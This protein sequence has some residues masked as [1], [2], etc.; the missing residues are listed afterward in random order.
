[1]NNDKR[2]EKVDNNIKKLNLSKR[3]DNES[4]LPTWT[5]VGAWNKSLDEMD[6]YGA[7]KRDYIW[8]SQLG[9]SQIDIWL[10]LNGTEP[11]NNFDIRAKRK[12]DAGV[13]WE[14][15]AEL[16]AKRAGIFL[17]KQD[18]V[19]Y[20]FEDTIKVV[21]KFDLMIG[22]KRNLKMIEDVKKALEIISLP[23]RF[24]KAMDSV[25]KNMNFETTLPARILEVKSSSAFM[26]EAQYKKGIPSENHALQCLHYL[27]ATEMNEGAI[28]YISKDDARM[29]EIP[30]WRDDKMLNDK[31]REILE[32]ATYY[33]RNKEKP[34]LEPTIIFDYNKGKF[35][36]NWNIKYSAYLTMLY[37]F[38]AE[39]N[40]QDAFKSKI[41]AW[42]RVL[43]RIK[44]EKRITEA[45][46][47]YM[48]EIKK[49]FPNLKEIVQYFKLDNKRKE[50]DN[51]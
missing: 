8:A 19:E 42:N 50:G 33:Y 44:K 26:Y 2:Q 41:A 38:E 23:D 20:G 22:G 27:L 28:L 32:L 49:S 3:M 24:V 48:T 9:N 31:Y 11:S 16:V 35:G 51:L 18:R 7:Y 36:D 37:G 39:S 15:I 25:E 14:W 12:F 6:R 40:Y 46:L 10:A 5:F 1:M 43:G 45:N 47:A 34:P 17:H 21:G 30:I 29:M 13:L 4:N